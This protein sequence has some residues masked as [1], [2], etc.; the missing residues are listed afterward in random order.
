MTTSTPQGVQ[1]GLLAAT[2][3]SSSWWV[4]FLSEL[5]GP[6]TTLLTAAALI[7]TVL[8]IYQLLFGRSKK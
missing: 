8:K 3:L 2:G 4:T 7:L 1:S 5:N 6:L